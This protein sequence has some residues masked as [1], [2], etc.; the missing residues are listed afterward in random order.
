M[1]LLPYLL[2]SLLCIAPPVHASDKHAASVLPQDV[3]TFK[4][5]RDSCNYF[6]NE[7]PSLNKERAK[8][9]AKRM[10]GYCAGTDKELASLKTKY[11]NNKTVSK[12]LAGYAEK[13]EQ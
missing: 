10:N 13:T 2:F 6:R 3:K 4:D 9:L 1:K 7:G 5:R 8:D 11:K 12:A